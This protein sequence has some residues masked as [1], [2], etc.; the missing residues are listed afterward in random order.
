MNNI[1]TITIMEIL[2]VGITDFRF[3]QQTKHARLI[4][5]TEKKMKVLKFEDYR[6]KSRKGGRG[7]NRSPNLLILLIIANTEQLPYAH[8]ER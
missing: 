5:I 1:N 6:Q 8:P 4:M 2:C 3:N 7:K